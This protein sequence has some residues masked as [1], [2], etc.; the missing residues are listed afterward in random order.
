MPRLCLEGTVSATN[1]LPISRRLLL[2]EDNPDGRDT[3]RLVLELSGFEVEVAE[4]GVAGLRLALSW[5]PDAAV[6][7]IG[8]PLLDGYEV[9]R[10]IRET[11]DGHIFLVALTG[12][13]RDEDRRRAF[14]AGFDVHL[15]KPA[16]L[17]ELAR[18][19]GDC[20]R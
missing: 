5:R 3:L 1:T 14:Q 10:R 12:Y 2:V 17:D 18:L 9:A 16:D 7:D 20:G 6:V 8:L 11:L 13:G 15:T 4:D 19:L